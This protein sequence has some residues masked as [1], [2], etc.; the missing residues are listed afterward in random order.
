M[1]T[2]SDVGSKVYANNDDAE[3]NHDHDDIKLVYNTDIELIHFT[4]AITGNWIDWMR[5]NCYDDPYV[6]LHWCYMRRIHDTWR[7]EAIITI[8]RSIC[9]FPKKLYGWRWPGAMT[10]Y[11]IGCQKPQKRPV[12][13]W[14]TANAICIN[15]LDAFSKFCIN[16]CH[17]PP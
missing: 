14:C 4:I 7:W 11:G 3:Y 16:H 5:V 1:A 8:H 15:A 10:I 6:L 12:Y 13:N 17:L 2:Q 9:C